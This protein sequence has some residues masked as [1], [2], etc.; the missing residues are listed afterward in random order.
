V[1]LSYI[2]ASPILARPISLF[3]RQF[4]GTLNCWLGDPKSETRLEACGNPLVI[5]FCVNPSSHTAVGGG[6]DA[7]H[8]GGLGQ[9]IPAGNRCFCH[10]Q[11]NQRRRLPTLGSRRPWVDHDLLANGSGNIMA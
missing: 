7:S 10:D 1:L 11:A 8:Y 6:L 5:L 3:L 2:A 9:R 4:Q